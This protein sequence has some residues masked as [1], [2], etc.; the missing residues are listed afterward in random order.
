[1]TWLP[2]LTA[3]IGYG[4]SA[5]TEYFRDGR[6]RERDRVTAVATSTRERETREAARRV[7]IAERRSSFQRE[8]LLSLQD[9]IFELARASGQMHHI[10][11]MES[12]KTGKWG[13]LLFPDDLDRQHRDAGVKTLTLLVRLRDEEVRALTKEFRD[14]ANRAGICKTESE[15]QKALMAMAD[16]MERLHERIGFIVR[17]LD[18]DDDAAVAR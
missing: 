6:T 10:E 1:M 8:T 9:A 3:L 2:L 12:R 15:S 7:Q 17:K 16:A 13:D 4:T 18:D 5:I 11:E 14:H